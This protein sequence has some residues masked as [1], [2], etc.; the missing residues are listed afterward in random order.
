M[1]DDKEEEKDDDDDDEN[2]DSDHPKRQAVE[3]DKIQ[4]SRKGTK[5][6]KS[7]DSDTDSNSDGEEEDG[8]QKEEENAGEDREE[9][10]EFQNSNNKTSDVKEGLTLFIRNVNYDTS[11]KSLYTLFQKYGDLAYCKIVVDSVT[12]HSKGTAFVKFRSKESVDKCLEDSNNDGEFHTHDILD[13]IL[14]AVFS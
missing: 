8:E 14:S 7:I 5:K 10:S 4:E 11:E 12:E 3:I 1:G 2:D 9:D 13:A 6:E